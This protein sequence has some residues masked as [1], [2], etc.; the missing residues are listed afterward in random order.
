M[1]QITMKRAS[2]LAI[3]LGFA[4]LSPQVRADDNH[5]KIAAP[6]GHAPI[7]V[8]G[9]HMH[10]AGEYMISLRH[11][12]MS[13]KGNFN[14]RDAIADS[15]ILNIA[16]SHGTPAQ[17]R[18]VP[19]KMD[20][21]MTMLGAMY[22]PS[23]T[24]TLM[25]MAMH[26]E[27]TM[28]LKTY[29]AM[30]KTLLGS[31]ESRSEG[32]GDTTIGA[33]FHGGETATGKWHYGLGLSLPTGSIKQ[34][35]TVLTPMNMTATGK[36]LPYPMQLG[37]G[38]YDLKPS[39]TYNGDWG[40]WRIGGQANAVVRLNDNNG[41]YRLGDK[42]ELH[43]WAMKRFTD[44][45]SGS[46]RIDVSHQGKIDGE[47][48]NISLPVQTAQTN[49]SGGTFANLSLGVNLIGQSGALANHRLA[50]EWVSPVHQDVHGVQMER[51]DTLMIGWQKAF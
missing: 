36:R 26:I 31:F 10:K 8:M 38:S 30:N 19:Q 42:A 27:N 34:T 4:C 28:T 2:G 7:M 49:F 43:G 39:V 50:I 51:E 22:A 45:L 13:M 3:A 44:W 32:A 11:M 35:G 47:D 33:L 41:D 12:D 40:S 25:L 17:L 48:T 9:D 20:M 5:L 46:V 29:H 14:G 21:K 15:A 23:D 37:S 16:N 1:T 24:V 6:E 18:V